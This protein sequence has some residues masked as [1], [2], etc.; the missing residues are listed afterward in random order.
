MPAMSLTNLRPDLKLGLLLVAAV[1]LASDPV[2]F[3]NLQFGL[4]SAAFGMGSLF[5]VGAAFWVDRRPPHGLMVAG[6]LLLV[7]RVKHFCRSGVN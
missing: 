3:S 7:L 4:L 1:L 5:V 6:A 2:D